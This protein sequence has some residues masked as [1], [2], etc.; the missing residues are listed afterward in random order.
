MQRGRNQSS[1]AAVTDATVR[2]SKKRRPP[3]IKSAPGSPVLAAQPVAAAQSIAETNVDYDLAVDAPADLA[4]RGAALV[5]QLRTEIKRSPAAAATKPK[6]ASATHSQPTAELKRSSSPVDAYDEDKNA[7]VLTEKQIAEKLWE[8]RCL[9]E[10]HR[11]Q[12]L[13]LE[14]EKQLARALFADE[15]SLQ[16]YLKNEDEQ[17]RDDV[18]QHLGF[19]S[20]NAKEVKQ[21]QTL[22]DQLGSMMLLFDKDSKTLNNHKNLKKT[23]LDAIKVAAK[24][25]CELSNHYLELNGAS[26]DVIQHVEAASMFLAP[27]YLNFNK[28]AKKFFVNQEKNPDALSYAQRIALLS[29]AFKLTEALVQAKDKN[30][31]SAQEVENQKVL[32]LV[33]DEIEKNPEFSDIKFS[34]EVK[35]GNEIIKRIQCEADVLSKIEDKQAQI[36]ALKKQYSPLFAS[37]SGVRRSSSPTRRAVGEDQLSVMQ[38]RTP[39]VVRVIED[40]NEVYAREKGKISFQLKEAIDVMD[41]RRA[42]AI[43][44]LR[45]AENELETKKTEF[46]AD[47]VKRAATRAVI[48][49]SIERVRIAR[50]QAREV[51]KALQSE[52]DA[53][54]IIKVQDDETKEVKEVSTS[55]AATTYIHNQ[56]EALKSKFNFNGSQVET[57][58]QL[59]REKFDSLNV[60]L[61]ATAA[62]IEKDKPEEDPLFKSELDVADKTIKLRS[63]LKR[64]A[65]SVSDENLKA[66]WTDQ[67]KYKWVGGSQVALTNGEIVKV[68]F[69]VASF[70]EVFAKLKAHIV[71]TRRLSKDV[72]ILEVIDMLPAKIVEALMT[73]LKMIVAQRDAAGSSRFFP[74]NNVR[75]GPTEALYAVVRKLPDDLAKKD[76]QTVV[77]STREAEG[78][79]RKVHDV[80]RSGDLVWLKVDPSSPAISSRHAAPVSA[81]PSAVSSEAEVRISPR[82]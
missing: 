51:V 52:V 48:E 82:R 9:L 21:A 12:L 77:N 35:E 57:D 63:F 33:R 45:D 73:K 42:D 17:V 11:N 66:I 6:A 78:A 24:K 39:A 19:R 37:T 16:V 43:K 49:A 71:E 4:S 54:L 31:R 55:K 44:A 56:F 13:E 23:F 8:Q 41:K 32:K 22:N 14:K 62:D 25:Y 61:A 7:V 80:K 40:V 50:L 28:D 72:S 79:L 76:Y 47:T 29:Q 74:C 46:K 15:A 59:E 65:Q 64:M 27:M 60:S 2:H 1:T 68:P 58:K 20:Q 3:K 69:G 36:D 5:S 26:D 70:V 34:V 10:K 38:A 30:Y 67:V 81:A 75:L 18:V 53:N